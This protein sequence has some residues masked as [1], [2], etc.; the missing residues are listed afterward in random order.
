MTSLKS[1]QMSFFFL[2]G[3]KENL[4][5]Y[6]G[7]L[8]LQYLNIKEPECPEEDCELREF[9]TLTNYLMNN[10]WLRFINFL[11]N[12]FWLLQL[13]A[14]FFTYSIYYVVFLNV[15]LFPEFFYFSLCA[16]VI[17]KHTLEITFIYLPTKLIL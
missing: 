2:S 9:L 16:H 11:K 8:A 13:H 14:V 1:S 12:L 6:S 17:L 7:R 5:D 3:A 10:K 15:L 4:R